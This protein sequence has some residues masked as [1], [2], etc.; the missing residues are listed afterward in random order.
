MKPLRLV[1]SI[2]CPSRPRRGYG[3]RMDRWV[4]FWTI[5]AAINMICFCMMRPTR[6]TTCP[7]RRVAT[8]DAHDRSRLRRAQW[9]NSFCGCPLA[10]P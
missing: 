4:A 8:P 10:G 3:G 6:C 2:P 9:T 7:Q 1:V 5:C